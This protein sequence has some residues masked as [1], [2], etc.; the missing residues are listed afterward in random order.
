MWKVTEDILQSLQVEERDKTSV[1]EIGKKLIIH[2][3]VIF[4]LLSSEI[5][6]NKQIY[7]NVNQFKLISC[8][9]KGV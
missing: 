9:C 2:G 3:E 5:C 1:Y 7:V 4:M 8:I 6:L